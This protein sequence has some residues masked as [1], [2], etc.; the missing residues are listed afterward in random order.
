ML[1]SAHSENLMDESITISELLY[2]CLRSD[3]AE[4]WESLVSRI[5]PV[6]AGVAARSAMRWG[7]ISPE[8]VEDLTQEAFLKMCRNQFALLRKTLGQPDA[9]VLAFMKVIVA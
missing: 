3:Q 5:Q 1:Q 7:P 2:K 8:L 4:H 9:A 6:V